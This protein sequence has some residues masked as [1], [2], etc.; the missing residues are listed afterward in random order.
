MEMEHE[1][2]EGDKQRDEKNKLKKEDDKI[3]GQNVI[4]KQKS[5]RR[6]SEDFFRI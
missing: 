3:F 2:T 5:D 1:I 4:N 6:D